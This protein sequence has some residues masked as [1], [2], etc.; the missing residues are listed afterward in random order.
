[1]LDSHWTHD[2]ETLDR[3]DPLSWLPD[4]Y[5]HPPELWYFD[6]NSLGLQSRRARQRVE[7]ALDQWAQLGVLGWNEAP[8]P[9]FTWVEE[10]AGTVSSLL[11]AHRGEV[12]LGAS[13]TA[14]LH[15]MLATFWPGHERP[16][17]LIDG[18]AFPT[19]RYAAA[20]FLRGHGRRPDSDMVVVPSRT[21]NRLLAIDELLAAVDEQVG[22]VVLPSV[23]FST[24]QMLP[25]ADITAAL[26]TRGVRVIWDLCHTAG[27]VPHRLHDDIDLAVFC[28]YKYLNGGPGAPAGAFVH[29]SL[30]PLS[31]GL[32]GWWGSANEQQFHMTF[33]FHGASDAHALQM[34]TPS[35]LSLAAL[36]GS[37]DLLAEAGIEALWDRSQSLTA[38]LDTLVRERLTR[39]GVD[40]VTP[41]RERGG[42]IALSHPEGRALSL[43][44]R[45][46]GVV[47]DF[48]FPDI[49]R[50]APA[51]STS[52]FRDCLAVVD[53]LEHILQD[54]GWRAFEEAQP[55]VL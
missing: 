20:S 43:A 18:M 25:M 37:V 7:A 9:W 53:I 42:H 32:A 41:Q 48:R 16:K 46:A 23:V 27:L 30:W 19:D 44:L 12:T 45:A 26:R 3:T 54:E 40:V 17:I 15:Q 24:G 50:L 4:E 1:M 33:D 55:T 10:I 36:A 22:L 47:P 35:I 14:M 49:I 39:Y 52:R 5:L 29:Q 21:D 28:T 51:P 13:T 6:G 11:G 8:Q 31:P 2:A 38:F 34:G